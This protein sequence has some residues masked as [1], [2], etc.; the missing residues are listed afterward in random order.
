[1][2][3]TIFA[4][5]AYQQEALRT[6]P[7]DKR[8]YRIPENIEEAVRNEIGD[9]DGADEA[10]WEPFLKSYDQLIWTLG[11]AGEAGEFADLMKKVHGH[12]HEFTEELR[13]KAAKELGD[14]LWYLSVLAASLGYDLS[15]I[16]TMNIEK[17]RARY[18]KGFT[19]EESK[20]RDQ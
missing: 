18:K 3:G 1:M 10:A 20:K 5:D 14:V 15:E 11:L 13:Q 17:L 8:A 2:S 19:I 4:F 7:R 16:A 12:G 6:A 9:G